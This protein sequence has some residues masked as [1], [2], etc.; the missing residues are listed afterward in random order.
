[1][2]RLSMKRRMAGTV[3]MASSIPILKITEEVCHG[4]RKVL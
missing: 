2:T 4:S 1:M 3:G